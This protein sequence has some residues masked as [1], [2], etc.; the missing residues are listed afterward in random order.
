MWKLQKYPCIWKTQKYMNSNLLLPHWNFCTITRFYSTNW[1]CKRRWLAKKVD[2]PLS[3]LHSTTGQ[4]SSWT[5]MLDLLCAILIFKHN[6]AGNA[7]FGSFM[8]HYYW[9]YCNHKCICHHTMPSSALHQLDM[10]KALTG[11]RRSI[12]R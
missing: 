6:H 7:L 10:Q 12:R 2:I 1:T 3:L 9:N 5:R 11:K 4:E 8:S